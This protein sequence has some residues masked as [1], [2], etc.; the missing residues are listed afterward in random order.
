MTHGPDILRDALG[1]LL[2][3]GIAV[4]AAWPSYLIARR[5]VPHAR[6]AV[7]LSATGI[8]CAWLLAALFWMTAPSGLFRLE[9]VVPALAVLALGAHRLL[10][11][12]AGSKALRS[13]LENVHG[14]LRFLRARP[15]GWL[16]AATG[17]VGLLRT[18]RGTGAPPLG[19]DALTYHLYK[20]GRW[21]QHGGLDAQQAPDAWGNYQYFP[22]VGDL[23]WAWAMLPFRSDLAITLAGAAIWAAVAL[24]VYT[25]A[26]TLRARPSHA[27]LAAAG[28]T[29]MPSTLAY[30]S[31]AYVDN[32]TLALF[33]LGSLFVVRA[34]IERR[35]VEAPLA[36]AALALMLGVK[37][38]TAALFALGAAVVGVC[39]LRSR[40][41]WRTRRIVLL[42]CLAAAAVGAP[43]YLRAWVEQGSP[44]Y[45]FPIELGGVVLS[46]GSDDAGKVAELMLGEERFHLE[47]RWDFWWYIL[48]RPG[49]GGSFVNPG[50]GLLFFVLLAVA[51]LPFLGRDPRRL[52][53][54]GFFLAAGG[55][56]LAGFLS[57][58]M[59]LF[60]STTKVTTCGRYL[61]PGI[62]AVAVVAACWNRRIAVYGW[63]AAVAAGLFLAF[64]RGW[65]GA[66][67]TAT[68]EVALVTAAAGA[69][70]ALA[71]RGL[72]N[73]RLR[74]IPV[75]LVAVLAAS[76]WAAG[77]GR[78][79][80]AHRYAV[81]E[82]AAEIDATYHMHPLHPAY[83]SAWPIWRALDGEDG[84]TLAATAGWDR[85]G[86]NW[87]R[88]PLLGSRLQNRVLYVPITEDGS[89]VDYR[90][91][92]EVGRRGDYR[93]WLERLVEA[94][95]EYVVSLAPRWTI[96]DQWMRNTPELFEKAVTDPRDLHAAFRFRIEEA[97]RTL[98]RA[99][100][101]SRRTQG[102]DRP[103]GRTA[104]TPPPAPT[105]PGSPGTADR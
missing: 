16:L 26:V 8:C 34:V 80:A 6:T 74:T 17:V 66:G 13:D 31:S 87:Y 57:G 19:W 40:A 42:A 23:Y 4:G 14:R 62:A 47:S 3:L 54:V 95:V 78:V 99:E 2:L 11:G 50:P 43:S 33:L 84:H 77:V 18:L 29:A 37:L 60:R 30:L 27:A 67:G 35:P 85:L 32:T 63:G 5:L 7:R 68:V 39:V 104:S 53:A 22:V 61:T 72:R 25:C 12:A 98:D 90:A 97:R 20:A 81:Y 59:D 49:T 76:A 105:A 96:E 64:P 10:G 88:Y 1:G 9:V 58:N 94:R 82:A 69:L 28:V 51:A 21:V 103:T 48:S 41:S 101:D 75:V 93:A 102:D 79:R 91:P 15:A 86:H 71:I 56:M 70:V 65:S 100:A 52:V 38:T 83:A 55:I 44:F 45:P 24:A 73:G 92:E 89:I 36:I 46:E